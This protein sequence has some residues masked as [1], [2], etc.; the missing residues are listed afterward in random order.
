MRFLVD[1]CVG[2]SVAEWLRQQGHEVFSIYEQARGLDDEAILE[3]A[4]RENWIVITNDKGFGE[5]VRREGRPHRGVVLM[6]LGCESAG[7]MIDALQRLLREYGGRLADGLTVV[8]ETQ[9]RFASSR[10]PEGT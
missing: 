9:V 8:T 10:W 7:E 4:L 1:E 5:L 6:R 2:P 3:R